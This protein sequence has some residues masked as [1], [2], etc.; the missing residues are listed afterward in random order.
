[1]KHLLIYSL[2]AVLAFGLAPQSV[3]AQIYDASG[4]Y[5]DTTFHDHINRQAEDF[6]T[7]SL[8]IAD[9]T[10]WRDDL[11]G[12]LGHAFIRLQCPTFNMDYCFSYESEPLEGNF[13]R[14]ING[15]LK[16]GMFCYPTESQ[17]KVYQ[18]WNRAVHEYK[19]NLP[20]DAEQRLWQIMDD[21]VNNDIKLP[22]DMYKRGC[23]IS[24]VY[25]VEE[26]LGDT[27]IQY[28]P[29]P[30]E[31]KKSRYEIM[32]DH[33]KD[34]PWLLLG[35]RMTILDKRFD[36]PCGNESKLVI[37]ALLA[38]VWQKATIDGRPLAV[39]QGD[40]TKGETIVVQKTYFTPLVALILFILIV[41]G[42]IVWIAWK[43]K[44][45]R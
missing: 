37:P 11:M 8:L 9:P 18:Q 25:F 27:K 35:A 14:A 15:D 33:M 38:E 5:V 23:A 20:P 34:Y 7:V 43:K 42:S 28:G 40:L 4:Q 13:W 12:V 31:F 3:S 10:D 32:A 30:E 19:L 26:A 29:W 2:F 17:V 44:K 39:Y 1:M 41:G 21:E 6:V 22:L 24:L 16:M 36:K 45:S